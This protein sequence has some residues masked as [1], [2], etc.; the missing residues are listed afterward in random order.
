MNKIGLLFLT[1]FFCLK[2]FAL[3]GCSRIDIRSQEDWNQLGQEIQ[4]R[5][6][7]GKHKITVSIQVDSLFINDKILALSGI[8]DSSLSLRI[9]GNGVIVLPPRKTSLSDK[10]LNDVY[11]D[12]KQE[13]IN[14]RSDVR[15][16]NSKI[17]PV[18]KYGSFLI[19][20]NGYTIVPSGTALVDCLKRYYVYRFPVELPDLSESECNDFYILLTRQWAYYRHKVRFVKNGYLYFN[21]ISEEA[22]S[23]MQKYYLEPNADLQYGILTRYLLINCPI[24][25]QKPKF[26]CYSSP[27][28]K[29]ND[30][31]I[32]ELSITGF[33][34]P[35]WT[36]TSPIII[37]NC[38][39]SDECVVHHNRFANLTGIA[40]SISGSKNVIVSN[41]TIS[42]A[43]MHAI[44]IEGK[45][46]VVK[47]NSLNRIGWMG[48]TFAIRASGEDIWIKDN[49]ITDFNY[50]AISIGGNIIKES[51]P[52]I[53]TVENNIIQFT[54][55]YAQNYKYHTLCDAG[56]IY[57]NPQIDQGIIRNNVILNYCGNAAYRGIFIDDG[58][59]NMQISGNYISLYPNQEKRSYDLDLRYCKTYET[60]IPD[61]NRNNKIFEN[62]I[63]GFYRFEG[64]DAEDNCFL[65]DNYLL[66][67][68]FIDRNVLSVSNRKED[69]YC[70]GGQTH[71]GVFS[72]P[73]KYKKDLR[74]K[75]GR[76]SLI[77]KYIKFN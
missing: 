69:L 54:E 14:N 73:S 33:N 48:Q 56:A 42:D 66:D 57:A 9:E 30:S 6:Q 22:P 47:E 18:E 62:L 43:R 61:H 60:Y 39:F 29:I 27:F 51:R 67:D 55:S 64:I 20:K 16:I 58:G 13:I 1:F 70:E 36:N 45:S 8:N 59:K 38:S 52:Q 76:K 68:K 53:F 25:C 24:D 44:N 74:K 37:K 40:I 35:Y 41:N 17:E 19:A 32:K 26:V 50:S 23:D 12:E 72:I 2:C 34:F 10:S 75:L 46:I 28:I 63:S 15:I 5:L 7:N 71:N 49:T 31:A 4:R 77:F 11:L 3:T 65:G 21:F